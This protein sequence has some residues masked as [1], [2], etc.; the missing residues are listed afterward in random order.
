MLLRRLLLLPLLP[1]LLSRFHRL[2]T[3]ASCARRFAFIYNRRICK[4]T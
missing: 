2:A 4:L 1:M 3:S